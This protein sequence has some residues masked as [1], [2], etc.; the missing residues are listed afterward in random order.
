MRNVED[1]DDVLAR[2]SA[3]FDIVVVFIVLTVVV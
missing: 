2:L 3:F 1:D